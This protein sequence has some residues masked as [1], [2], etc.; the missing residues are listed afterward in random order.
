MYNTTIIFF[1]IIS[2]FFE[3]TNA[4]SLKEILNKIKINSD[5]LFGNSDLDV[6]TIKNEIIN[7]IKEE[8]KK[9]EEE[10]NKNNMKDIIEKE[11]KLKQELIV[12]IQENIKTQLELDEENLMFIEYYKITKEKNRADIIANSKKLKQQ[13]FEEFIKSK[14]QIEL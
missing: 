11:N 8:N 5:D 3:L 4:F 6:N 10:E 13:K 9:K 7:K 14:F 12:K 1:I 2:L